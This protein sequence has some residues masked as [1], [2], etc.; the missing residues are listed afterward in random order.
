MFIEIFTVTSSDRQLREIG[1]KLGITA[2]P[3]LAFEKLSWQIRDKVNDY[4]KEKNLIWE[5]QYIK[6]A[7]S[8]WIVK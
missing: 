6:A 5:T 7:I 8:E 2:A 3:N 1:K 4:I